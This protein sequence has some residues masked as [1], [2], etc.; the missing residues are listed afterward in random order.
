MLEQ[1]WA[2]EDRYGNASFAQRRKED[3]EKSLGYEWAVIKFEK[4]EGEDV[5]KPPEIEKLPD[6]EPRVRRA[7]RGTVKSVNE[8]LAEMRFGNEQKGD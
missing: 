2:R 4:A 3:W 5:P 6:V 1:K 7:E 8:M